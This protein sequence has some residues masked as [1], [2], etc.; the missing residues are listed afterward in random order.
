MDFGY[1]V[2]FPSY[3]YN[4]NSNNADLGNGAEGDIRSPPFSG[5]PREFTTI[6][7]ALP[8]VSS[9][10]SRERESAPE[11]SDRFQSHHN[12]GY[13]LYKPFAATGIYTYVLRINVMQRQKH[14]SFASR[15]HPSWRDS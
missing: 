5:P 8:Q 2:T 12:S 13:F 1:L 14:Q 6:C 7:Q 10:T 9:S 15:Y 11:M 4:L 3:L